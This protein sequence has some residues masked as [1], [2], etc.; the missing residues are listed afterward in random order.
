MGADL[1]HGRR[2]R[3]SAGIGCAPHAPRSGDR[4]PPRTARH[5]GGSLEPDGRRHDAADHPARGEAHRP[6]RSMETPPARPCVVL[7]RFSHRLGRRGSTGHGDPASHRACA[8]RPVAARRRVGSR[9][10]LGADDLEAAVSPGLSPPP[11]GTS[12]RM[13]GGQGMRAA[14]DAERRVVCRSVLGDHDADAGGRPHTRPVADGAAD[15]G[16]RVP[17]ARQASRVVRPVALGL[18]A[19][20]VVVGLW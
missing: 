11:A 10:P 12:A 20:A 8:A 14:R 7:A 16:H 4:R 6:D 18:A 1:H 2:S 9:R 15:G 3:R 13:E 19:A 5:V 17:E